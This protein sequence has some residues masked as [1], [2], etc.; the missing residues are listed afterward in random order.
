MVPRETATANNRVVVP[1]LF[2]YMLG[3]VPVA[4]GQYWLRQHIG[5]PMGFAVVLTYLIVLR[6]AAEK[7]GKDRKNNRTD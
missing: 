4:L 1:K 3:L 2:I 6:L 7:W 5:N